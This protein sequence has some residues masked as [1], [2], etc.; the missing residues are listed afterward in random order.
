MSKK[1][2]YAVI[3]PYFKESRSVIERCLASVRSQSVRADHFLVA[4]GLPQDWLDGAGVRHFKLDRN[5]GDFGNTPR[6]VGALIAIGEEYDGIALLD[7]DNWLDEDH[8]EACLAA[9]GSTAT[10]CDYVVARRRFRRPNGTVM[11][12]PEE[13]GHVDTNCFFFLRGAF[14]V[15]PHWAMMPKKL[16]PYCDRF[17]FQMLRLHPFA[18]AT[19]G[20]PTVNYFCLWEGLYLALGETPPPGAK[21]LEVENPTGWLR[22]LKRREL[23][24][25]GRLLGVPRSAPAG[26]TQQWGEAL[27]RQA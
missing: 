15:L 8:I 19:V 7:A 24:I 18:A 16:S 5:H 22:S 23:E 14:A 25:A 1:A 6:G 10:P 13:A 3:T 20:R 12:V 26:L 21:R 27:P 17:F 2:R 4:D 11:P 9:A